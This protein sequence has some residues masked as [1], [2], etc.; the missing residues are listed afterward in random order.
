[1]ILVFADF[2]VGFAGTCVEI[3]LVCLW[4]GGLVCYAET[5][6]FGWRIA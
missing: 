6:D 5:G 2:G 4:E 3:W 1:M